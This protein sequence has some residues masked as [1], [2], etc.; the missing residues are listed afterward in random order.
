[1]QSYKKNYIQIYFWQS[2]AFLLNFAALFIVTP[3]ISD[4]K[5]IF[6]IYSV[7]V[8]LN[9]FLQYADFGFLNAGKKYTAE[10]YISG[11][12][13][14]EKKIL[15][16]SFSIFSAV[17]IIIALALFL[18]SFYPNYIISGI[19]SDGC[20]FKVASKLLFISAVSVPIY[21]LQKY[22]GFIY[23]VRLRDFEIQRAII[24]GSFVRI[25]SVPLVFFNEHYDIV[26]YY[27]FSQVVVFVITLFVLFK[28]RKLG[29]GLQSVIFIVKFDK[30][31]FLEIKPLALSGFVA[32]LSWLLYYEM[33]SFVISITMGAQAVAI[34]AIGRSIQS[35]I[36]SLFGI[37]YSPYA[38]RFN[39]YVGS[40]DINGLFAF[41]QRLVDLFS[42][43][44]V[45]PLIVLFI[46]ARPFVLAWVG[47]AYE[48]SV[49]VLQLL[50]CCYIVNYFTS[51]AGSLL[52]SLNRV[53]D[54]LY[55]SILEPMVFY[56]GL[57]ITM[58]YLG[59][60]SVAIFK[61]VS[62][63]SSTIFYVFVV[64]KIVYNRIDIVK[65][66]N[67]KRIVIPA[68]VTFIFSYMISSNILIEEK[69]KES[70]FIIV[71]VMAV[72]TMI[73]YG[74]ICFFDKNVKNE[75]ISLIKKN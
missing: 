69:S 74:V 71:S 62:I 22:T 6:G 18:L 38:V 1:M 46:F 47:P 72:V 23:S 24:V 16:T 20:N 11:N 45:A 15:G 42:N 75:I 10:A 56:I 66:L 21:V 60:V 50:I 14:K 31:S 9:V 30:Q 5:D 33:D 39:Y 17:C 73:I 26:G 65:L 36:R 19:D 34:Y 40:F 32:S 53:R 7:C 2:I 37:L 48:D 43:I 41:F 13:L 49:L 59:V 55:I 51:P 63:L 28:S 70:L 58:N 35:V 27:T 52:Y 12:I 29:Y 67:L 68:I 57:F 3:L 4:N 54:V 8:G 61:L 64:S 25:V 44:C